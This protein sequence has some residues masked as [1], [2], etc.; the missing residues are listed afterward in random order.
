VAILIAVV[1]SV[2]A[3]TATVAFWLDRSVGQEAAFR[4]NAAEVL[5]MDSSQEAL[6]ARLMD[7]AIGA[8]P[9]LALVRGAGEQ[10]IVVLLD[11]GA[12]DPAMDRIIAEAH[13]FVISGAEGPFTADLT[14]VREVFVAP[15]A[16]ISPDLAERIPVDAFERVVILDS[17]TLPLLGMAARWLSVIAVFAAAAAVFLGVS[18]VMLA[19]RRGVAVVAVGTALLIAGAGVVGWALAGG[20]IVVTRI[21]DDLTRVLV[22]NG[23]TVFGRSL[24]S[25]GTVLAAAG[26]AIVVVGLV[27]V[28]LATVRK[29]PDRQMR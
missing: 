16:R 29:E 18:A 2:L 17:N 28:A 21:S 10:A 25:A 4:A 24:R 7:E 14:D 13:R 23:Y 12:F 3:F 26:A 1:I 19:P 27:M 6:A 9:L 22:A 5:A 11:S 8:V 15:I 20:D